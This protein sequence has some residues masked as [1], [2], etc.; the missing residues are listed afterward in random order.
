LYE[1]G[2]ANRPGFH[3]KA[4]GKTGSRK[5]AKAQKKDKDGKRRRLPLRAGGKERSG[6]LIRIAPA[7]SARARCIPMPLPFCLREP[8]PFRA[9]A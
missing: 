4:Q 5:T 8:L 6:L 9:F 3:A 7:R 1:A 2:P